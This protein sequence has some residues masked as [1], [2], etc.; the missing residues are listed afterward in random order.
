MLHATHATAESWSLPVPLTLSL[1]GIAGVYIIGWYRLRAASPE[2]SVL[3]AAGFLGG[4]VSIWVAVASALASWDGGSLTAHMI[5]HLLLMTWAPLLILLSVPVQCLVYGL[6]VRRATR[7]TSMVTH[8]RPFQALGRALAHPLLCWVAATAALVIW[9]VPAIFAVGLQS[10]AW[11]ATEQASFLVSGLLFWWPVIEPWPSSPHP[12]WSIVLYLFLATLPCDILSGFLMF[13]DR[14]VYS[15]YRSMPGRDDVA[16]L[17]DQQSA[18]ALMWTVVT[19][20]YL[21]AGTLSA[22]RLLARQSAS[23]PSA[24]RDHHAPVEVH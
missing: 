10:S 21:V 14:I 9:H 12:R 23:Q 5:Q 19:I 13:S 18:A 11:H 2:L 6:P 3:H 7:T 24:F 1:V 20:I 15:V 8:S 17:S 4:L 22:T 16:I